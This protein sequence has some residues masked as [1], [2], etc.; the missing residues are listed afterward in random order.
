M[1]F[2]RPAAEN[3]NQYHRTRT[4]PRPLTTAQPHPPRH[5][6][7]TTGPTATSLKPSIP[8]WSSRGAYPVPYRNSPPGNVADPIASPRNNQPELPAQDRAPFPRFSLDPVP[9]A[10]CFL[11]SHSALAAGPPARRRRVAIRRITRE[12][13]RRGGIASA[14]LPVPGPANSTQRPKIRPPSERRGEGKPNH[15]R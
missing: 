9:W 1:R 2:D 6:P 13:W 14:K 4:R 7:V 11:W 15:W 12:R 3:G 5:P 10:L 8:V